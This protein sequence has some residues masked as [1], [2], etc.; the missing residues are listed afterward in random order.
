ML[1]QAGASNQPVNL[2]EIGYSCGFVSQAHFSSRFRQQFG[3][4]PS[5]FE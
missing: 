3:V 1:R 2:G 4:S 5:N